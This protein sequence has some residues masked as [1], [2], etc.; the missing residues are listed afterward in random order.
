VFEPGDFGAHCSSVRFSLFSEKDPQQA[1]NK[2]ID[3]ALFEQ[4]TKP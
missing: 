2:T 1:E 4:L 3:P